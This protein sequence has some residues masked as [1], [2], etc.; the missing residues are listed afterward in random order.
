MAKLLNVPA[1]A[2]DMMYPDKA[3]EMK[4]V[5][6]DYIKV[7][8]STYM[9][10]SQNSGDD[11]PNG[12]PRNAIRTD[13]SGF[14]LVPRPTAWEK[15]TKADLEPIYRLYMTK[16]YRESYNFELLRW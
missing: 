3:K 9:E 6:L 10:E 7:L 13:V 11:E 14:P 16:H 12:F 4:R 1:M 2:F 8:R 15:V 5:V